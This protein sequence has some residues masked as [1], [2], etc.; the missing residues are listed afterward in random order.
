M[1][2][3]SSR[4]IHWIVAAS[5]ALQIAITSL[6]S[7]GALADTAV[8]RDAGA[9]AARAELTSHLTSTGQ[10]LR[11]RAG[12]PAVGT[13][14]GGG[15]AHALAL[16]VVS[17]TAGITATA[18]P[19]ATEA[20]PAA[21]PSPA[22]TD[23]ATP[24][25]T[26]SPAISATIQVTTTAAATAGVTETGV[27]IV[28]TTTTTAAATATLTATV[29][30]TTTATLTTTAT[31]TAIGTAMIT[32]TATVTGTAETTASGTA[33][34]AASPDARGTAPAR[35]LTETASAA[36]GALPLVFEQNQGQTDA[37]ALYVAHGHGSTLF[38]TGDG[39]LLNLA[40]PCGQGT[41]AVSK[42]DASSDARQP[43]CA[44]AGG[45]VLRLHA[46][47]T[48]S[49]TPQVT[50]GQPLTGTVNYLVGSDPQGWQ[51][52]IPT[53]GQVTCRGIYAGID[54][55]YHGRGTATVARDHAA[56]S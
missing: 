26:S 31:A 35:P 25:D 24:V 33:A 29:G 23:T 42:R 20:G 22:P 8:G 11:L 37:Q 51:T 12:T 38:V 7:T 15:P 50:A 3:R 1:M 18:E 30:A 48:A 4:R 53:F 43:A 40:T 36:Y 47:D 32:A 34:P 19:A 39:V 52:G 2:R 14:P 41:R 5:M 27:T 6:P 10:A 44:G 28:S 49:S 21:P 54:L 45:A 17:A 46:L 16:A 9:V 56:T 13:R 55:V